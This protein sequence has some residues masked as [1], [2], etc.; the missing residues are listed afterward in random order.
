MHPPPFLQPSLVWFPPTVSLRWPS[1]PAEDG[2]YPTAGQQQGR[3]SLPFPAPPWSDL[4]PGGQ[5]HSRDTGLA[6]APDGSAW[7]TGR[8]TL[9]CECFKNKQPELDLFLNFREA[10]KQVSSSQKGAHFFNGILKM[11]APP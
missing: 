9:A 11:I 10:R 3:G 4:S 7:H 2:G 1:G 8:P 5:K 6:R